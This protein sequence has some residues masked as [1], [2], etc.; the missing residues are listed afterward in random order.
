MKGNMVSLICKGRLLTGEILDLYHVLE[1]VE[2][3]DK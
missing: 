2:A 3:W 1:F